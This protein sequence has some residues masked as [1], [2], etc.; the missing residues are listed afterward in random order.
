MSGNF[1]VPMPENEPVCDYAP[2]TPER[3]RLK[4]KLAE[5]SSTEIEI[6]LIIGGEE[7]RTG[8]TR[9]AVMPHD[10]G[11]ALA[12]WHAGGKAEAE[13]AIAAAREAWK[14]WSEWPWEVP[15]GAA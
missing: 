15:P 5:L 6:P 8:K 14:V 13:R 11:H 7:V 12:T 10:H 4:A 2:G 9:K 1:Q 3:D